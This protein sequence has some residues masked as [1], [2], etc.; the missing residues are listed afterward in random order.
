MDKY[1]KWISLVLAIVVVVLVV[2]IATRPKPVDTVALN[3]DL[4][5]FTTT[6]QGWQM[7]YAT[8]SNSDAA[9]AALSSDLSQFS[10]K[11]QQDQ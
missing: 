3:N 8:S 10:A 1:Y 7:Q 4:S 6:L 2:Y 5:Q 11:I 9:K